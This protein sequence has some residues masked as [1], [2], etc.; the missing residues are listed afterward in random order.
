MNL[1]QPKRGRTNGRRRNVVTVSLPSD[2]LLTLD[3]LVEHYSK[4]RGRKITRSRML[5]ELI[6]VGAD[7]HA[8]R[9]VRNLSLLY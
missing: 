6:R 7:I 8:G 2:A 5:R 3:T 1:S 9:E 4:W